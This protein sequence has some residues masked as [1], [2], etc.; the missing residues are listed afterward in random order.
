MDTMITAS[1]LELID[2]NEEWK[3]AQ[4]RASFRKWRSDPTEFWNL[5]AKRYDQMENNGDERAEQT[6]NRMSVDGNTSVVDIGCGP[7]TVSIP[8][9][10]IAR[11]LTAID[12]SSGML[13]SLCAKASTQGL[14]NIRPINKKW[15]DTVLGDDLEAHDV[16]VASYSLAMDDIRAALEKMDA[17]STRGVCLFWFAGRQAWGRDLLWS[18]LFGE[19]YV[20][21]PDHIYLLNVLHQM[22]IHPNVEIGKRTHVQ[23]FQGYEDA[24][25]HWRENFPVLTPEQDEI[26]REH[27]WT[28]MRQP[29]GTFCS[30]N[31]IVTAMVW[32]RKDSG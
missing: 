8:I 20:A 21:G 26:V 28:S 2:W 18:N 6:V 30:R 24:L 13:D 32:W 4:S 12:P 27:V 25:Q 17:A 10:R 29:D 22:G 14:T 31:H 5:K 7:G 9:A 23:L 1:A 19:S 11:T 15:E 16:V 3:R